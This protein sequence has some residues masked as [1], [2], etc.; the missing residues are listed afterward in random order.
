MLRFFSLVLSL[1]LLVFTAG[2]QPAAPPDPSSGSALSEPPVAPTSPAPTQ[3]EG[4]YFALTELPDL[5]PFGGLSE[6]GGRYYKE[7]MDHLV[8]QADYGP[9]YPYVGKILDAGWEQQYKYGLTTADGRVVVDPVYDY[10]LSVPFNGPSGRLLILTRN[11]LTADPKTGE[12]Q[13]DGFVYSLTTVAAGDGSWVLP[14]MQ[15]WVDNYREGRI[16]FIESRIELRDSGPYFYRNC[17]LFD[18]KGQEL[19]FPENIQYTTGYRDGVCVAYTDNINETTG[20]H[21]ESYARLIDR[22]GKQIGDQTFLNA[23][24]FA[25]GHASVQDGT[26]ELWG[27]IDTTGAYIVDPQYTNAYLAYDRYFVVEKD[28]KQGLL[29]L[30]GDVLIPV[31]YQE[32]NVYDNGDAADYSD[33]SSDHY[34]KNL[35]TGEITGPYRLKGDVHTV[36]PGG[37]VYVRSGD[38]S[39][40]TK[41][42][43]TH[44]LPQDSYVATLDNSELFTIITYDGDGNHNYLI[45]GEN[46]REIARMDNAYFSVLY[47]QVQAIEDRI[48]V[49]HNENYRTRSGLWD[50]QGNEILPIQYLTLDYVGDGL[51]CVATN[52]YG[53]L[54][55]EQGNWLMRVRIVNTD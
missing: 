22:N 10:V 35:V 20:E 40:L 34:T 32:L 29:D 51:F 48:L 16:T 25:G 3:P 28:G 36:L 53:G 27:L 26:S 2:C 52:L 46:D 23:S 37:W 50:S 9:L 11:Q 49:N 17:R 14:E 31:E 5:A 7:S 38:T 42:G 39:T 33:G 6:I 1:C 15:G 19:S 30:N 41:N 55:D 44:P 12:I 24:E 47:W 4:T 45:D 43:E 21:L 18:E 13:E 8:S 54:I